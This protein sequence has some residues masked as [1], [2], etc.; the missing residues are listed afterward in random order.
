[1]ANVDDEMAKLR[2]D[3]DQLRADMQSLVKTMKESGARRTRDTWEKAQRAGE[4]LTGEVDELQ[5]RAEKKIG[6]HPL[7]TVLSSFG[8]GFLVGLLLD[9]RH[10]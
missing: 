6:D 3:F 1:M 2:Q 4:S 5:K 9:R 7:T 8:L 10:H